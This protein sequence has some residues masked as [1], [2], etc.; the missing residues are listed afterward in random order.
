[1]LLLSNV[2]VQDSFSDAL[3][4]E[5]DFGGRLVYLV[6]NNSVIARFRPLLERGGTGTAEYGGDTLL[7][8]QSGT[9]DRISGVKFRNAEAG[10]TARIIAILSE[11]GDILPAAGTPFSAVLTAAGGAAGLVGV[12]VGTIA[13]WG[14]GADPPGWLICDGRAVDRTIYAA[15]FAAIGTSYGPGDGSTT[16]NIPDLRGRVAVGLG[17]NALV[18]TLGNSDGVAVANRRP[19]HRH[20]PH[21]HTVGAGSAGALSPSGS[22][23]NINVNTSSVD[24]GSGVATDSLDAPAYQVVN[25]IIAT[26]VG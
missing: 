15:L 16:F 20:T 4:M 23:G 19:K 17:T 25:Y 18:N 22:V 14:G 13:M 8:P 26:G 5:S 1:M 3:T 21:V 7:T 10:K 12:N 11:P 6:A 2:A 9:I 24:G